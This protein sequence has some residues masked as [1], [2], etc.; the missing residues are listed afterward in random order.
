MVTAEYKN[1]LRKFKQ[2]SAFHLLVARGIRSYAF[3]IV[4]WVFGILMFVAAIVS[5]NTVL[6]V[7]AA[8]LVL[9]GF[10]LPFLFV[11]MQNGRINKRYRGDDGYEKIRQIFSF[12]QSGLHLLLKARGKEEEYDMPY[13]QILRIYELKD[14]YY[15]YIGAAHA[16]IIEKA[17]VRE[18]YEGELKG[19][20]R[21]I[22]KRFREKR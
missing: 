21:T 12:S 16:L 6:Y 14:V 19:Y 15:V 17:S 7:A 9:I 3:P 5:K 13:E 18:D 11:W 4:F 10:F 22:G 8:V 2:F 1:D 20:F